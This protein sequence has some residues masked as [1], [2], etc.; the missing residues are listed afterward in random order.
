M[1][2]KINNVEI[3]LQ[4]APIAI[5][6]LAIIFTAL[7]FHRVRNT[8]QAKIGGDLS[9]E[10]TQLDAELV[11]IKKDNGNEMEMWDARVFNR[12]EWYSF[13]VNKKEI[14]DKKV[15]NFFKRTVIRYYD[16]ML[17]QEDK[18]DE[19]KYPELKKLYN[20]LKKD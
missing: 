11:K 17:P 2:L 15:I 13:L 14:R 7:T 1:T 16:G 5:S 20:R 18:D 8:E 3:V 6:T 4:L 10:L 19:M 12:L 9:K